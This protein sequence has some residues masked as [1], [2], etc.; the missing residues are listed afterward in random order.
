MRASQEELKTDMSVIQNG[1]T[2]DISAAK[3]DIEDKINAVKND[4]SAVEKDN[5][6]SDMETKIKASQAGFEERMTCTLLSE[7]G[8]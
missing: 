2:N 6:D 3:N 5:E 4:I 1:I 8:N 7:T